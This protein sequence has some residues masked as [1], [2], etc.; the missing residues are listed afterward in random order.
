MN[1]GNLLT[2]FFSFILAAV[3]FQSRIA[4][5]ESLSIISPTVRQVAQINSDSDATIQNA[6]KAKFLPLEVLQISP[7]PHL[8]TNFLLTDKEARKMYVFKNSD[9]KKTLVQVAEFNIDIGKNNGPKLKRDDKK[10]PEG[11][12]RLE[13]KKT[14][15]EI[16]FDLYG[17]MAFTTDYPN[18]F[19]KFE[20]KTGS[21]IWLHSVPDTVPLTRGSKGCVV[22]RNND[23]KLVEP[24]IKLK[25]TFMIINDKIHWVP[26]EDH[27]KEH[28]KA[29][30]W[31]NNWKDLWAAQ[32]IDSYIKLYS[33]KFTAPGFKKESWYKHKSKLKNRYNF[34]KVTLSEPNI[35]KIKNHYLF[36]VIQDYESDGHKDHGVKNLYATEDNG[37]IKIVREEWFEVKD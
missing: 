18:V 28:E 2:T 37:Q 12:Y 35:F 21:G 26:P 22:I 5:A 3:F 10:T 7:E 6:E 36:Q 31:I 14:P 19:D 11:I 8:N 25:R 15:P 1:L 32:D 17:I 27:E 9:D 30:N 4:A 20:N 33:D 29:L 13:T 34:T 16:P 23:L 24:L